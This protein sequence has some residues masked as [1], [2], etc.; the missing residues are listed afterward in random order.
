MNK[1]LQNINRL[2]GEFALG[3]FDSSL[4]ISSRLDEL[5][6][7]SAGINMLAEELRAITISR[8]YFN[9][10]FNSVSDMVFVVSRDGYI[11]EMNQSAARWLDLPASGGPSPSIASSLGQP[12]AWFRA[13]RSR[14]DKKQG[15]NIGH[16][17]LQSPGGKQLPVALSLS[18]FRDLNGEELLLFTAADTSYRVQAENLVLRAIIDTQEKERQR[19]AQDLHDSVTQQLSGIKF[20]L[21]SLLAGMRDRKQYEILQQSNAGLA[22][23]IVELRSICFHLMPKTLDEFGLVRAIREFHLK[24]PF[25]RKMELAVKEIQ[26][27]PALDA[28]LS[29]DLYRIVQ[30]FMANAFKHGNATR[31]SVNFEPHP[32][33]LKIRLQDNG[34]GFHTRQRTE[35]MGLQNVRSRLRSHQATFR[36]T[37]GPGKGVRFDIEI[38]LKQPYAKPLHT[39]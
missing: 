1:R 24:S 9:S 20:S 39:R 11:R 28:E 35:G 34:H 29:I 6:A 18:S 37:T 12:A 26:P 10:I 33:L 13:V 21:S 38:P 4:P 8:N 25:S 23:L 3:R 30:E 5:D 7:I 19:L 15:V 14:L 31:V 32:G 36:I 17:E 27:L 22:Q 16:L 2:L